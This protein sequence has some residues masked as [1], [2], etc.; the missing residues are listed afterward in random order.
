MLFGFSHNYYGKLATIVTASDSYDEFS[1]FSSRDFSDH[2]HHT[3]DFLELMTESTFSGLKLPV[4]V[5]CHISEEDQK[6][7]ADDNSIVLIP[8]E[9]AK[10][11]QITMIE[12]NKEKKQ[13]DY[14]DSERQLVEAMGEKYQEKTIGELLEL[15]KD[16][17]WTSKDTF[18]HEQDLETRTSDDSFGSADIIKNLRNKDSLDMNVDITENSLNVT[19]Q[20][21][22]QNKTEF[23]DDFMKILEAHK[24][25]KYTT[26]NVEDGDFVEADGEVVT[27]DC[28]WDNIGD[29]I[30]VVS[31]M[32]DVG[33][34][35]VKSDK[36]IVYVVV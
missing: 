35:L 36:P 34:V 18:H 9:T 28:T 29:D 25:T 15:D 21:K 5:F 22:K 23:S 31:K 32:N 16:D 12:K 33:H 8:S 10:G 4:K 17:P 13:E 14:E 3:T 1:D 30:I 19:A 27:T 24:I 7:F 2:D 26:K 6:K 20:Y 11:R